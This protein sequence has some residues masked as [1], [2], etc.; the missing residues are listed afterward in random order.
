MTRI[1]QIDHEWLNIPMKSI[2]SEIGLTRFDWAICILPLNCPTQ[3]HRII[4]IN[5]CNACSTYCYC[6]CTEVIDNIVYYITWRA[7]HIII[8]KLGG[9]EGE[10][11]RSRS[12]VSAR[13]KGGRIP[14]LRTE[15]F[16]ILPDRRNCNNKFII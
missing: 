15:Y 12:I 5:T 14:R 7:I 11:F 10:I 3:N 2:S 4:C 8:A 9:Q 6:T 16:P 13:P 1:T